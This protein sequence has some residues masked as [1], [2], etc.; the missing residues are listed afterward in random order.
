MTPKES[1][2]RPNGED[3]R[4]I[5]P[6]SLHGRTSCRCQTCDTNAFPSKMILP[7]ILARVENRSFLVAFR[8]GRRAPGRLAQRAGH[9]GKC[10]VV[11]DGLSARRNRLHMIDVEAGFL[12]DL[13]KA[14]VLTAILGT[15]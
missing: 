3:R 7:P 4:S 13:G 8:I 15:S 12:T 5:H 6:Q 10:Q 14:T 9:A 11:G 1:L 2:L